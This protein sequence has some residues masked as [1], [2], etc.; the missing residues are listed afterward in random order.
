MRLGGY[1]NAIIRGADQ[2]N[3]RVGYVVTGVNNFNTD[4]VPDTIHM[5]CLQFQFGHGGWVTVWG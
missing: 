3:E 1:I 2:G 4:S 5:R